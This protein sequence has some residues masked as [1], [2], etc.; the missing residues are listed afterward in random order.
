MDKI[1]GKK[2]LI[3]SCI[4]IYYHDD[5]Y[6]AETQKLIDILRKNNEILISDVSGFEV[7]KNCQE[8]KNIEKYEELLNTFDSFPV[9]RPALMN[10]ATLYYLYKK[11]GNIN[12]QDERINP[13][14]K[15]TGDLI[16]G[17]SVL[18]Y[19]NCLL[20]TSNKKDFP[21]PCWKLI[22]EHIIGEAPNEIKVYLLEP[23]MENI[24]SD[25][26]VY[27]PIDWPGRERKYKFRG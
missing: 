11:S 1:F 26:P 21:A 27:D 24:K 9:D 3:D 20:L 25:V 8:W 2:V 7:F 14:N 17:G 5:L 13:K 19:Q 15:L 23:N 10:A 22:A 12:K 4:L 6:S 16:I 18:S